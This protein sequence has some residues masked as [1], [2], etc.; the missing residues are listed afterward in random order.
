MLYFV[1]GG[2]R[3]GKSQFAEN[4]TLS[5]AGTDDKQ[6]KQINCKQ[7]YYLAT[8]TV[9]DDEMQQRV[10]LHKGRRDARWQLLEEPLTIADC[11]SQL[12][13]D[14]TVLVDCMTLWVTNWLCSENRADFASPNCSRSAWSSS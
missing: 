6:L 5:L 10:D 7:L 12:P 9:Y 1:T 13:H 14:S 8:A 3:S 11:L 2:A 4:L